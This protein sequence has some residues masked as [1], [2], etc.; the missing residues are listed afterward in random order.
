MTQAYRNLTLIGAGAVTLATLIVSSVHL[1]VVSVAASAGWLAFLTPV[2]VD[3]LGMTAA[4]SL[5]AARRNG[6]EASTNAILAFLLSLSASISG[7]VLYPFLDTLSESALKV[8]S[9]IVAVYPAIAL[10]VSIEL[11]LAAIQQEPSQ[12]QQEVTETESVTVTEVIQPET[13]IDMLRR[14]MSERPDATSAELAAIVGRSAS[15]VRAKRS[16]IRKEVAA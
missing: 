6:E 12:P 1:Y 13:P 3:F 15:W 16:V 11:V 10:A 8:L 14:L 9:A 2:A 7:N 5:W 4:V